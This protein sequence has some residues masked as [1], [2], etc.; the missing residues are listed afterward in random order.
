MS[1]YIPKAEIS[2]AVIIREAVR[3]LH[4][5]LEE[6]KPTPEKDKEINDLILRNRQMCK[7]DHYSESLIREEKLNEQK[8]S[9]YYNLTTKAFP[10]KE[11]IATATGPYDAFEYSLNNLSRITILPLV[12]NLAE[13]IHNKSWIESDVL[14]IKCTFGAAELF[15]GILL[16]GEINNTLKTLTIFVNLRRPSNADNS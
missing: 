16:F 3:L 1:K 10:E 9:E 4:N 7:I 8:I 11:G 13:Q 14:E 15:D 12:Y 5:V 6:R 2:I